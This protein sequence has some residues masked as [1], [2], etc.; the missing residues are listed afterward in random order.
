V[1]FQKE[2]FQQEFSGLFGAVNLPDEALAYFG[3]LKHPPA[4]LLRQEGL[5]IRFTNI[6][7]RSNISNN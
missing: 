7:S 4:V 1:G 3:I 2:L 6:C 5:H